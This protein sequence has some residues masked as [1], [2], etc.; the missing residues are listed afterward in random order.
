MKLFERSGG[1]WLFWISA[2]YLTLGMIDVFAHIKIV[3]DPWLQVGYV[4]ALSLP[5][6]IPPLARYLNM[7]LIWEI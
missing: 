5:L 3:P 2:I 4:L 7:K 6:W 1:Y